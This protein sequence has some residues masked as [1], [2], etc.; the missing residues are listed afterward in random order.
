MKRAWLAAVAVGATVL[1]ACTGGG[2]TSAPRSAVVVPSSSG[3][4]KS[5]SGNITYLSHRT[6]LD[7]DGTY[8][9]YIAE[10]NKT[11]PNVHVTIQSDT[12]YDN[13]T[14]TKLSNGTVPDVLDIPSEVPKADLSRYFVPYGYGQRVGAE[15][16]LGRLRLVP[17]QGLRA[18]HLRQRQRDGRQPASLGEGRDRSEQ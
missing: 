11:Y 7:Q 8:K 5:I 17:E 14:L 1:S 9:R 18:G 2:G 4:A 3:A 13:D 16:Q 12:N 10:F 15:V 6:D